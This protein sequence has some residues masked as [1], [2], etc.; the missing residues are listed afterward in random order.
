M[1]IDITY[2]FGSAILKSER[3]FY[4]E[5]DHEQSV[6]MMDLVGN[7]VR[8]DELKIKKRLLN[9]PDDEKYGEQKIELISWPEYET[10]K[11]TAR[12]ESCQK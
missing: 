4:D 10:G 1:G 2:F 7:F 5:S 11:K 6:Q 3:Y 8:N 12:V 9:S